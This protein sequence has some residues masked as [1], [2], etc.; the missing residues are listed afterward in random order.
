MVF[1]ASALQ[2]S[3]GQGFG[4]AAESAVPVLE[5]TK[6]LAPEI[7]STSVTKQ[8]GGNETTG[9]RL[10]DN[11]EDTQPKKDDDFLQAKKPRGVWRGE[12]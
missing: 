12:R 9:P 3:E 4:T 7:T 6:S 5:A 10:A 11:T 2:G 8:P 1:P